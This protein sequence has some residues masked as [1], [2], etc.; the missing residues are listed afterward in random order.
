[1]L[2]ISLVIFLIQRFVFTFLDPIF[3]T[4]IFHIP[5][6]MASIIYVRIRGVE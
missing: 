5:A 1:M 2:T 6:I 4:C 3:E